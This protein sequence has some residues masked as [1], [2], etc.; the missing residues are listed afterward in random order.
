MLMYVMVK[1]TEGSQGLVNSDRIVLLNLAVIVLSFISTSQW[2]V[3]HK[4]HLG[5]TNRAYLLCISLHMAALCHGG[6]SGLSYEVIH[7]VRS[8]LTRLPLRL[9]R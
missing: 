2:Y 4:T 3:N 9:L 5:I 6:R 8:L 7:H 1:V